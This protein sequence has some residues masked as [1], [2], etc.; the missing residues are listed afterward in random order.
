[1]N[2]VGRL[3]AAIAAAV[4]GAATAIVIHP[5]GRRAATAAARRQSANVAALVGSSVSRGKPRRGSDSGLAEAVQAAI[6]ARGAEGIA[7]TAHN[8]T[9]TLRGEVS[10]LDDID[11]LEAAARGA[12]ARD[13]NNLLRLPRSQ[14]PP[15]AQHP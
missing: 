8:G 12:G 13:V 5:R 14:R 1:M 11:A 15:A 4:G 2:R 3:A 9:V 6:T 10:E 7:V